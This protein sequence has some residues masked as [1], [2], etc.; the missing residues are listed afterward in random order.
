MRALEQVTSKY[1]RQAPA[2]L[3]AMARQGPSYLHAAAVPEAEVVRFNM[4]RGDELAFPLV[5][6]FPAGG[7]IW[8]DQPYCV[9][10]NAEWVDAEEAEAAAIFRD[11]LLAREQQEEGHFNDKYGK[12]TGI[13]GLVGMAFLSKG[14]TPGNGEYGATIDAASIS[15]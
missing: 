4:E 8:A 15:S 12:S 2:L 10:D 5:F 9:L 6:I 1:G 14:H 3:D 11:F 7:T 13:V